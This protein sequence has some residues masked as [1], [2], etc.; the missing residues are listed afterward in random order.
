MNEI[1]L[2]NTRVSGAGVMPFMLSET[3]EL[4]FLLGREKY[5]AGWRG[6][7]RWSAFEGGAHG[8][9]SCT[10]TAVRE[11]VEESMG[12]L[13]EGTGQE[14]K[15]KLLDRNYN[16]SVAIR[17]PSQG[18]S[19]HVTYVK[20][21]DWNPGV[22]DT[23]ACSRRHLTLFQQL[24]SVVR[25][26]RESIP[27]RYPYFR[28][29]DTLTISGEVYTVDDVSEVK[30]E[31]NVLS[32]L[33]HRRCLDGK[34]VGVYR[35]SYSTGCNG[36]KD[37]F[38]SL[39]TRLYRVRKELTDYIDTANHCIPKHA[40]DVARTPTGM[41]HSIKINTDFMEKSTVRLWSFSE[42]KEVLKNKSFIEDS[43]RPYFTIVLDKVIKQFSRH[44]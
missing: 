21:F 34:E 1:L 28:S 22:A 13:T 33:L 11:F 37:H 36:D 15:S 3:G 43:F 30:Y 26:L 35:L 7:S 19:V 24:W 9:E 10:D 31:S 23:F 14:L 2:A 12:C 6:S 16:M 29:G 42:L 38:S 18:G 32:M 8:G 20:K 41:I 25:L 4:F 27:H 5:Q 39:Y 44:A 17:T 40:F